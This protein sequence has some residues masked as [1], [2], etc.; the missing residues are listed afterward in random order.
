MRVV[1]DGQTGA[2]NPDLTYRP[3]YLT[4]TGLN[5]DMAMADVLF[6]ALC[7]AGGRR[8]RDHSRCRSRH[9]QRE[10]KPALTAKRNRG[11]GLAGEGLAAAFF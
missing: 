7:G 9:Q 3:R 11:P 8:A 5:G 6:C 4:L 2:L 10:L 1:R